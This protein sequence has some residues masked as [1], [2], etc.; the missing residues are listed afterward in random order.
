MT[1]GFSGIY[2]IMLLILA[3]SHLRAKWIF[4]KKF[5]NI[6]KNLTE[7]SI[8]LAIVDWACD[9]L[10]PTTELNDEHDQFRWVALMDA[11]VIGFPYSFR[12]LL[13]EQK[14]F[15]HDLLQD[16]KGDYEEIISGRNA[17]AD[18][19]FFLPSTYIKGRYSSQ[20]PISPDKGSGNAAAFL[21]R[22]AITSLPVELAPWSDTH[23]QRYQERLHEQI[24]SSSLE[25]ITEEDEE[26]YDNM[27]QH[28]SQGEPINA[29]ASE[30]LR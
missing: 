23:M 29:Q 27:E 17:L 21:E 28:A 2:A 26:L 16:D 4:R 24:R 10:D 18:E 22:G 7:D 8:I 13:V 19:D 3:Y 30:P 11:S 12:E 15:I 1:I 6:G 14:R 9:L 5:G 25:N 20:P